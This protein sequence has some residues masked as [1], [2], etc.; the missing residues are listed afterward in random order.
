MQSVYTVFGIYTFAG[1][2]AAVYPLFIRNDD[3]NNLLVID[4]ITF[5][6]VNLTGGTVLPNAGAYFSIGFAQT[7]TSG[8]TD[9][10]PVNANRTSTNVANGL[11]K[12]GNPTLAGTLIE[13]YRIYPIASSII[14]EPVIVRGNDIILGR[15]KSLSIRYTSDNT[16]GT[17]IASIKFFY[18]TPSNMG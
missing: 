7:Y 10:V 11:F 12:Q 2:A 8:G 14:S 16:A 13:S 5:Q 3:P 9:V 4:N 1:A 6:A 18:A 17:L 15:S